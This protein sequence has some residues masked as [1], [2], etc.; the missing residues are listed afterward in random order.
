MIE[1]ITLK[2]KD[3]EIVL[4]YQEFMDLVDTIIELVFNTIDTK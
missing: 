4:T 3:Q 1:S 2:I